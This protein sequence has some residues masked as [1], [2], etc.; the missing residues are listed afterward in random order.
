MKVSREPPPSVNDG[1]IYDL[2]VVGGGVNGCGIARD[3]AG[4]GASVILFEQGDLAGAT[5]SASTKLIHGGLRYL[6]QY[7]FRLVSEALR[8]RAVLQAIAPHIIHP[9]RFVL[10]H[11]AGLRPR[12]MLRI[13]LFLYDHLGQRGGLPGARSLDL[14]R[15]AAGRALREAYRSGFE[16]SDCWVDDAR[17]VVLN[18]LDAAERGAT[19][20]TRTRMTAAQRE[21]DVWRVRYEGPEGA[22]EVLARRLVNAAGPWV[23]EAAGLAHLNPAHQVRLVK[24]S[25][26]VTRKLFDHDRA[27]IFQNA[28]GRIV[29]AIP[30]QGEFT[31]IG[32]TDKD[33]HGPASEVK[34]DEEE[35][36]YLCAAV[37][38]YFEKAVSPADVVWSYAGVRPLVD[39]GSDR[40]QETTRDYVLTLDGAVHQAPMLSVYGGKITTYR[41]LAEA[42]LRKLEVPARAWTGG[43]VLPGGDLPAGGLE[44]LVSELR[45]AAPDLDAELLKRWARAYGARA[46]RLIEGVHAAEDLGE[47]LVGDLTVREVCYLMDVEWAR[48]AEDILWRR[49]KLGLH[50]SRAEVERLAD[51]MARRLTQAA[52]VAQAAVA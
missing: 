1:S 50:A 2:A 15:D 30:Y 8:E 4:R 29:F 10:P 17:L 11:H 7:E 31:L 34:I 51:F 23:N 41:K 16:Y 33:W 25:H 20:L 47:R 35:V 26:I 36:E 39:D 38:E 6:E 14:T 12:W 42:A 49:T 40:P 22:G 28:D 3:A 27:Y 43:S 21:G 5:S 52:P 19:I 18:A 37:S 9:L 24:G 44:A 13:G 46:R 32:T 48:S 45:A